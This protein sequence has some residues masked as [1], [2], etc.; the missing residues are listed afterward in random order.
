MKISTLTFS[1]NN[2]A[3]ATNILFL[4]TTVSTLCLASLLI[5][6][7]P[8]CAEDPVR[9][10][11]IPPS[12]SRISPAGM[13]RGTTATFTADGRNLSDATEILFDS[14][15]MQ[16]KITQITDIPEKIAAPRAGEDL[17]AQVPFGKKQTARLELTIA[18]DATPG[19]HRFRIKTPLGTTNTMVLAVGTLPEVKARE[20]STMDSSAQLEVVALPAT[21]IGNIAAPGDNDSYQF[22]GKQGEEVLFQVVAS[23]LGSD[24]KSMLTLSDISGHLLAKAG[25]NASTA[26]A[27]LHYK[28]NSD[29]KFIVSITDR[30]HDGGKGY[31]YRMNAGRLPYVT[32]FFPLGVRAGETAQVSVQGI[33]LGGIRE[34]NVETPKLAEGWTTTPLVIGNGGV[35][36]L[37]EAKIAVGNEPE[38]LEQ[39]P[40]N[41]IPQAQVVSLP[42]TINGHIDGGAIAGSDSDE[43]YF[44]FHAKT[45]ERLTIDVAAAR[46]GSALDSVIEVLDE[47]GNSIPRATIRCLNQTT[48]TLADRDSR[49]VNTRFVST[50]ELHEGDYL[51]I[52][53]ELN[54]IDF[55]PDQPD[56]DTLLKGMDDL[57]VSYL[58]TS[59]DV[60]AVN[61]P[62]YKA[63]ILPPDAD[64]PSN[65]LPTFHLTWRNDDGGPGY[66]ADSG[67]DFVAPS[68]G[69]YFLHLKDVRGMEG[70]DFA[71]RLTIR[72]EIPDYRLK[73]EPRNPNIPQGGSTLITVS[74]VSRRGEELPIDIEVKGLPPGVTANKATIPPGMDS[75]V[76]VLSA[77]PDAP[78]NG[79]PAPIEI[80]GHAYLNGR[81]VIRL[82]NQNDETALQVASITP[83]PDV[84][85]TTESNAVSIEPGKDVTVTL[86]V[87]RHNGFKGRVP[88][89]VQNLPPGVRVVNVG[90]NGVLVTETQSSRTFTL[91]AEDWA[92][93]VS[94]PIYVV[95]TVESNSSTMHPSPPVLLNIVSTDTAS[96]TAR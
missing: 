89:F 80:V 16:G 49:S 46:L 31:F 11:I 60:H 8:L 65:G 71:Y 33:N 90:L 50:S 7:R 42:I 22:Q 32:S 94:Q 9:L 56:A 17:G 74:L 92:K 30:N 24:L 37:N 62:V 53:D 55:I 59:P 82:A 72:D 63:Q 87:D 64:L 29:G 15:G 3:R 84:V 13:Q 86:H 54:R 40:N 35:H 20:N 14:P 1:T 19:I 83:S 10:P 88:C 18:G 25:E 2:R 34:V 79:Y 21:L 39:E 93:P 68:D 38:S 81:D 66:G 67:L 57:R 76:I 51:M 52:G 73:A 27:T 70:P 78:L 58:G 61:T 28:L 96:Q 4:R 85:V 36:Q 69:D 12:I 75:T 47:H 48:T 77:T 44:R 95:G 23:Q 26:D 91:H 45:G 5:I 6:G 41:T 43:D